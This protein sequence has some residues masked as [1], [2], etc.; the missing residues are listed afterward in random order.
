MF[1]K[2]SVEE[3]LRLEAEDALFKRE[4]MRE[5]NKAFNK[6]HEDGK[7]SYKIH[8]W[9]KEVYPFLY[10]KLFIIVNIEYKS[11]L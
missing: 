9:E 2:E 4:F 5:L 6:K 3:K 10:V 8:D 11:L 7:K 1:S